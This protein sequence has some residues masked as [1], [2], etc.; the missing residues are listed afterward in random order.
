MIANNVNDADPDRI[1][2]NVCRFVVSDYGTVYYVCKDS[3]AYQ[4]FGTAYPSRHGSE[5][6]E[7]LD[8]ACVGGGPQN[9]YF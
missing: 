9:V 8:A 1:A 7:V 2:E 4:Y 3:D 5:Y 6:T